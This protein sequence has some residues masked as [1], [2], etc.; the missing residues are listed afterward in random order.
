[1]ELEILY[2][3][4]ALIAINKPHGLL[5]HRTKMA[6]DATAFAVQI[7]RNQ[8]GGLHVYP[9][10]RLDRKTAG[11][12]LFA[13]TKQANQDVQKL[14]REGQV[15]KSYRA[16][17]RGFVKDSGCIDY[18]LTHEDKTQEAVTHY[19]LLQHIELN[20]PFGKFETSRYSLVELK[21]TTGRFHQLRKHMA[22][23]LHPIIGDRPHGCNKQNKLWKEKYQ[24][25]TMCLCATEL[26]LTYPENQLI[27]ISSS[28]SQEIQKAL[29][30]CKSLAIH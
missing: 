28:Y 27:S 29:T 5:V 19:Q 4:Q 7:L 1:M 24:I 17:V 16:L 25:D 14:F 23:I 13:K 11:I 21:P 6:A 2:E 3:D 10:H 18:A 8:L 12:L 20:V 22:H 30:L 15:D 9:V 26:R